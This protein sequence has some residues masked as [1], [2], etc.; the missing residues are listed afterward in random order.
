MTTRKIAIDVPESVLPRFITRSQRG[1]HRLFYNVH[2]KLALKQ[3]EYPIC[4]DY[5]SDTGLGLNIIC[6]IK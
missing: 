6:F 5:T 1:S 4:G 3:A 2:G